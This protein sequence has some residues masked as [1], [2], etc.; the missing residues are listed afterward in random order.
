MPVSSTSTA[1][2]A[3]SVAYSRTTHDITVSVQPLYLNDQSHPEEHHF[4]W[5]YQVRIENK[6]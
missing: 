4:V 5:A 6:G 3:S 1:A 2:N